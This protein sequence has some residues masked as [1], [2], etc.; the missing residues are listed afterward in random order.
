MRQERA[1][2]S[3]LSNQGTPS[4]S[5]DV[6]SLLDTGEHSDLILR[7]S[8]GTVFNVHK[9]I[10][11]SQSQFFRNACKPE[12]FKVSDPWLR[13]GHSAIHVSYRLANAS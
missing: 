5:A 6:D 11:C 2:M 4:T 1:G 12:K 7:C 9:A 13:C 10:V 3:S 8:D